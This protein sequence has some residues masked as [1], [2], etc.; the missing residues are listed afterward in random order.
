MRTYLKYFFSLFLLF[1][2]A[3]IQ[4]VSFYDELSLDQ[5]KLWFKL[6]HYSPLRVSGKSLADG[7]SFFIS[8]M[9]DED[10]KA[11]LSATI[12]AF[13][14]L[15]KKFG[16][17]KLSAPCAFPAR[18]IFLEKNKLIPKIDSECPD[19]KRWYQEIDPVSMSLVFSDAY[20]NNPASMFGHTFIR[21]NKKNKT[22]DLLDYGA[23]YEAITDPSDNAVVYTLKGLFGGYPGLFDLHPYYKK[24]NSYSNSEGRNLWEY[25]LKIKKEDVLFLLAHIWEIYNTTY[26]D[27]YFLDE[28]CSYHLLEL[29]QLVS[30]EKL[31]APLRWFYL[32]RDI[33]VEL[34]KNDLLEEPVFRPS[35]KEKFLQRFNKLE[36]KEKESLRE[37]YKT[38]KQDLTTDQL[39][40]MIM[41]MQ[42]DRYRQEGEL[43][44]KQQSYFNNLL[45]NRSKIKTPKKEISFKP[46]KSVPHLGHGTEKFSIGHS[47]QHDQNISHIFYRS[48]YHGLTE[49][50]IGYSPFSEFTFLGGSLTYLHKD[51]K[52]T[53]DHINILSVTSLHPWSFYYSQLS[54]RIKVI[55]EEL[56][57]TDTVNDHATTSNLH[58]GLSYGNDHYILSL[59]GGLKL[60]YSPHFNE[61]FE[62][63]PS[64]DFILGYQFNNQFKF[65]LDINYFYNFIDENNPRF[66]LNPVLNYQVA[67]YVDIE[68]FYKYLTN[69][70]QYKYGLNIGYSF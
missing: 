13:N 48:G 37:S 68:A 58:L 70:N 61:N 28:N 29:I 16:K 9:G 5:Q 52:L 65:V 64:A 7:K 17:G 36:E 54:W 38:Y 19:W 30:E 2:T 39:D 31:K 44:Q 3:N 23:S 25:K 56:M 10:P 33:I 27:Y 46:T 12:K 6:L 40:T 41:L 20:P 66:T 24:V 50:D 67:Q 43:D 11:E 32:P 4:A 22:N 69:F 49:S 42:L 15:D 63:G 53:Y 21:F 1:E 26:F 45:I 57:E 34:Y 59:L 8:P 51:Q 60:R 55:N 62:T 47:Y 35:L 18:K 14:Q